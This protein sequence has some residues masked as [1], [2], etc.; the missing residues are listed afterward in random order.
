MSL[1][2]ENIHVTFGSGGTS[3]RVLSGV[4]VALDP[5]FVTAIVGPNGAG[6]STLVRT[7]MG[8]IEPRSGLVSLDGLPVGSFDGEHRARRLVYIPQRSTVVFAYAVREVVGMGLVSS[9][10]PVLGSDSSDRWRERDPQTLIARALTM[11]EL[12]DR[13]SDAYG[14]LS[15]GQQQRVTLARAFVQVEA[16]LL[17]RSRGTGSATERRDTIALLADEPVSAMDPRQAMAS[18]V[19][20]RSLA[21]ENV[22]VAVILHDLTLAAGVADRALLLGADGKIAAHGP[23]GD[24]LVPEVLTPALGIEMSRVRTSKGGWLIGPSAPP[25]ACRPPCLRRILSDDTIPP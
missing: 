8:F 11:V 19:L 10:R 23:A 22:A 18:L 16:A 17:S 12:A 21:R 5:G 3:R 2:L 7:A 1:R 4:D 13:A 20:L 6:K 24:V 15:A 25:E 9:R 14:D